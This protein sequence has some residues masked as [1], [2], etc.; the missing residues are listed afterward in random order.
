MG[1]RTVWYYP[2]ILAVLGFPATIVLTT[3][4]HAMKLHRSAWA[5]SIS[6]VLFVPV[7]LYMMISHINAKA[8]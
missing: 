2:L 3:I 6:G 4:E 1:Y 8:G 7:L 5:I